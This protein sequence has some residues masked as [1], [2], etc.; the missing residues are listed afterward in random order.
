MASVAMTSRLQQTRNYEISIHDLN[1]NINLIS[2]L[3]SDIFEYIFGGWGFDCANDNT[4]FTFHYEVALV[5]FKQ[6]SLL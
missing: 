1:L 6:K 3:V 2:S 4:F 5:F